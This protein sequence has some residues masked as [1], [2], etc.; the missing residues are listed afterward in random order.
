MSAP[1]CKVIAA[2][3][4]HEAGAVHLSVALHGDV[5]V[6]FVFAPSVV[7]FL[8]AELLMAAQEAGTA[9]PRGAEVQTT[10]ETR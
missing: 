2:T 1:I 3:G 9:A 4:R 6:E 7:P 8:I 5:R 10:E